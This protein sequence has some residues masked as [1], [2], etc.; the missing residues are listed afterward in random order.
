MTPGMCSSFLYRL[1]KVYSL[2]YI[3]IHNLLFGSTQ[4]LSNSNV[5]IHLRVGWFSSWPM[6]KMNGKIALFQHSVDLLYMYHLIL[7]SAVPAL[8][9]CCT[10]VL[11]CYRVLSVV[12]C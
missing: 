9:S 4:M 12:D 6:E 11:T 5:M 10:A 2:I 8:C 3:L 7:R 1:M